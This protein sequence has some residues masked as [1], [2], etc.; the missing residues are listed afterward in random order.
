MAVALSFWENTSN[1]QYVA[2]LGRTDDKIGWRIV[3]CVTCHQKRIVCAC[4]QGRTEEHLVVGVWEMG[5]GF[6][7]FHQLAMRDNV[8]NEIMDFI[9]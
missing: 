1:A 9:F 4:G 5:C 8:I 6:R 2:E 3:L 7:R